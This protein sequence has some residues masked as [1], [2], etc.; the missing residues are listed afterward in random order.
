MLYKEQDKSE[1]LNLKVKPG[2]KELA[3]K[4]WAASYPFIDKM[5]IDALFEQIIITEALKMDI[6]P[7]EDLPKD[8]QEELF[9]KQQEQIQEVQPMVLEQPIEEA[10]VVRGDNY[11]FDEAA[12]GPL[13][14][15]ISDKLEE[16]TVGK[17]VDLLR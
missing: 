10:E 8:L 4:L 2:V 7:F 9:K 15:E 17:A 6:V 11:I 14:G 16:A 1:K 3:S 5:D 12:Y 13:N